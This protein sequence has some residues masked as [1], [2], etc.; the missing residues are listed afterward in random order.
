V[1]IVTF[2]DAHSNPRTSLFWTAEIPD[3]GY[4]PHAAQKGH[5]LIHAVK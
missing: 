4:S 5:F 2:I 3:I 1:A